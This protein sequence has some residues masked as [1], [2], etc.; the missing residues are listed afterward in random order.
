MILLAEAPKLPISMST[1]AAEQWGTVLALLGLVVV[2]TLVRRWRAVHNPTYEQLKGR[3]DNPPAATDSSQWQAALDRYRRTHGTS[4]LVGTDGRLSTSKMIAAL[5]TVTLAY[6]LIVMGLIAAYSTA[7]DDVSPGD[8]LNALVSP[9]SNLYLVLLGGPFAAAVLSKVIVSNGVATGRI[10]KTYAATASAQDLTGND[11]GNTDLVDSQYTLFNLIALVIVLVAF[12]RKPGFGAPPIPD[13]LAI[14]TGASAATYVANKAAVTNAPV[15]N[16]V[17]PRVVRVG[18][19]ATAYGNNLYSPTTTAV[20]AVSVGGFVAEPVAGRELPSEISFTVPSPTGGTYP[21]DP[22]EVVIKTVAGATAV[23]PGAIRVV[24]DAITVTGVKTQTTPAGTEL[25]VTGSGFLNAADVTVDGSPR[26]DAAWPVVQLTPVAGG[27]AR[28][29]AWPEQRATHGTDTQLSVPIPNDTPA[30]DYQLTI[31]R[32]GLS[33]TATGPAPVIQLTAAP[34]PAAT[35]A[36]S[37][38]IPVGGR[39]GHQEAGSLPAEGTAGTLP[40]EDA[41]SP[42]EGT[43]GILPDEDAP[44]PDADGSG[45]SEQDP[46]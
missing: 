22:V 15:I 41:E 18:Q 43:A 25:I 1:Y 40:D 46:P 20:T 31:S 37:A 44:P 3:V 30:G 21:A 17:L 32:D 9:T 16:E 28:T 7:K 24:A 26:N 23:R 29:I 13:F 34:A 19:I 2:V 35:A 42:A 6:M 33:S 45:D 10:Q 8:V 12:V 11:R 36:P 27:D 39:I 5:W 4:V 14:L 38:T